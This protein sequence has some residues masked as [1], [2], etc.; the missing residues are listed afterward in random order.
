MLSSMDGRHSYGLTLKVLISYYFLQT[1]M[2][3]SPP[4][5]PVGCGVSERKIGAL[6]LDW[7]AF[8]AWTCAEGVP[9]VEVGCLELCLALI[10]G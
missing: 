7:G 3:E 10:V 4:V 2:H 1:C 9:R 8:L 5:K 6:V